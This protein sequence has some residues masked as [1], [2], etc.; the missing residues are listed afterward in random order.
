MKQY[1][2]HIIPLFLGLFFAGCVSEL[3]GPQGNLSGT[4]S[5][6]LVADSMIVEV[7]TRAGREL[8]DDEKS[9]FTVSLLQDGEAIWTNTPYAN[10]TLADR[11]QPVG[12]GYVVTAQS[13]TADEAESVNDGWGQRRFYGQSTTFSIAKNADTP[14]S[15]ECSMANAG[16]T[17]DFDESFTSFFTVGYS[18]TV[19]D[20]RNLK[21]DAATTNRVAYYNVEADG[22]RD[23]RLLINASAGWDGMLKTIDRTLTMQQGRVYRLHIRKGEHVIE[24]GTLGVSITYDETF[25]D[26]TT[27]EVLLN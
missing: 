9:S 23:V 10:V 16:L 4:F 14:V 8:T 26:G 13:C 7:E 21:F 18:V 20:E 19:V 5:L 12:A 24:T 6:G 1:I 15:V 2:K 3:D 27:E 11:T 25:D 22:T 17:V